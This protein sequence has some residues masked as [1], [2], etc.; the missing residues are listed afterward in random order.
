MYLCDAPPVL[1]HVLRSICNSCSHSPNT[2]NHTHNHAHNHTHRHVL[3]KEDGNGALLS[4]ALA[5]MDARLA[6]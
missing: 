2:H 1:G 6:L 4:E 3:T 5:W